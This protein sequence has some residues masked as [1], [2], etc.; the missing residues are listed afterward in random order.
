LR[1]WAEVLG[2]WGWPLGTLD[3]GICPAA[4]AQL[5]TGRENIGK[6]ETQEETGRIRIG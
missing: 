1:L 3:S 4:A 2:R 6:K 5:R